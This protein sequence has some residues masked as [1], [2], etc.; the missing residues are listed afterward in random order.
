MAK[1]NKNKSKWI[2]LLVIV[3][4]LGFAATTVIIVSRL[5]F[6]MPDDTGAIP[7]VPDNAAS[8]D[9]SSDTAGGDN[10]TVSGDGETGTGEGAESSKI[11]TE[12]Q[13]QPG[14]QVE[15]GKTIWRNN[16]EIEI[17]AISY[18]DDGENVTVR[19]DSDDAVIAPGTENSYT[20]KLKNTGEVA[21]D[22]TV[23]VEAYFSP[24][25][26]TVPITARISR[27]DGAWIVGSKEAYADAAELDGSQ[28]SA[29]LGAGR[30]TYYTLDWVWP[31][32]NGDDVYDTLLGDMAVEQE[33]SFTIRIRSYATESADP[34]AG[35]G[36]IDMPYTGDDS[37][38]AILAVV[39]GCSLVIIIIILIL[40]V[41]DKRRESAEDEQS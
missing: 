10:G 21:M 16:T 7:L 31:F 34:E 14:F 35:G 6:F 5:G 26:I 27:Y 9:G 33:I 3:L 36:I 40:K 20:F 29:T 19:S 13:P 4:F 18:G 28:D 24:A 25:D 38:A 23:S 37:Y 15:D 12:K 22:Y 17:F 1:Q 32:E 30:Y 11:G 2:W 8:D 41:K 39:A